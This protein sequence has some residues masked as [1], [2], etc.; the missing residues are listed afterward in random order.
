MDNTADH[1]AWAV[2]GLDV[3]QISL[4]LLNHRSLDVDVVGLSIRAPR[5]K[6]EDILM[7]VRGV[8]SAG[9]PVV[10]FLSGRELGGLFSS[11]AAFLRSGKLKW[12]VDEYR[13]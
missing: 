5:D 11:L 12:K 3:H 8:D 10:A 13:K 1:R 7:T 9:A 4:A 2:V 6:D